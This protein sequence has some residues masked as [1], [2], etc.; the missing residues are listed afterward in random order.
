MVSTDILTVG[1]HC[2]DILI[3]KN[4]E[5]TATLGGS[6]SYATPILK[7]LGVPFKIASKVG[8]DFLYGD[9]CA[10]IPKA[11]LK[12]KTTS[13]V[14]DYSGGERV[15]FV[16]AICEDIFP[17]DILFS[18]KVAMICGVINEIPVETALKVIQNSKH[19]VC[20]L[21]GILRRVQSNGKIAHIRIE[22][23]QY[24]SIMNQFVAV[25]ASKTEAEFLDIDDL[26]HKTRLIVTDG[27]FGAMVYDGD[28]ITH[29]PTLEVPAIDPTGAGD[30]FL[31]GLAY[32]IE[33]GFD[34]NRQIEFAN[35]C[36]GIAVQQVGIPEMSAQTLQSFLTERG[37]IC[38]D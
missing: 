1:H 28:K 3:G 7:A 9:R 13:F 29:F 15:E 16:G 17:E 20:D 25:K 18:A 33:Q 37:G 36:G 11:S 30:S 8:N 32:G 6:V 27:E 23:T 10:I 14:D 38:H 4:K 35:F 5:R 22:E 21:Q 2:H 26:K 34:L 12:T 31:A 19:T 24:Y